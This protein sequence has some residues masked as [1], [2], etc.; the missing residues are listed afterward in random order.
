MSE[1]F[2]EN[3]KEYENLEILNKND[4]LQKN[5]DQYINFIQNKNFLNRIVKLLTIILFTKD[6]L[7]L[8]A[9]NLMAAYTIFYFPKM[10]LNSP[11]NEQDQIIFKYSEEL[12]KS[13]ENIFNYKTSD[14]ISKFN[15]KFN[16]FIS[17]FKVWKE[18]DIFR[19]L[20]PYILSY[21]QYDEMMK[22]MEKEENKTKDVEIWCNE[23][24]NL[25]QKIE[26]DIHTIGGQIG[27]DLLYNYEHST[28]AIDQKLYQLVQENVKKAF[29]N[30]FYQDIENQN[31]SQIP[32]MLKDIRKM[33]IELIPNRNEI[34]DRIDKE[35]DIDLIKQMTENNAINGDEIYKIMVIIVNY[36]KMLQAVED[37]KDT[38]E[39]L[40]NI[41]KWFHDNRKYA[42]ILVNFFQHVFK[43][44]E[45]ITKIT[46]IIRKHEQSEP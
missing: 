10:V 6:I 41:E 4:F 39:F 17:F 27:I 43:K 37:D 21:Y 20:K 24:N 14:Y 18:Q 3:L 30:N 23:I 5:F 46:N 16:K 33:L 13:L 8:D 15:I 12:I 26:N 38:E 44:L 35:F 25:K 36:I 28:I 11:Q 9:K 34:H 1:D 22:E 2:F 19:I 42:F 32:N 31:Y 40:K 45:K 29:W 7:I